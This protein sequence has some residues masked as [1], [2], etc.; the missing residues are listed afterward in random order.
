MDALRTRQRRDRRTEPLEVDLP[1]E[2]DPTGVRQAEAELAPCLTAMVGRLAEPYRSAIELTSIQGLTQSDA[3]KH[4]GISLSGMKSRVQRGR[5]QLRR[6][7]VDCCVVALDVRGG[8]AD[9]HRRTAN[10][11]LDG[12]QHA[13]AASVGCASKSKTCRS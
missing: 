7:L 11:C 13:D 8:V 4:A 5:E 12:G 2:S 3:A 1:D 6:M 10:A 9:F